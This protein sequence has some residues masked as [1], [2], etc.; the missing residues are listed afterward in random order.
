MMIH[1]PPAIALLVLLIAACDPA[2]AGGISKA[3]AKAAISR[4]LARDAARDAATSVRS[5]P[6]ARTVWRYTTI[7]GARREATHGLPP[8]VHMT[9]RTAPGRM[10]TGATARERYGLPAT[11]TAR[12]T[13][14]LP[15]GL[16]VRHNKVVAGD[17]GVG[18]ITTPKKLPPNAVLRV[19]RLPPGA[20]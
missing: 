17:R 4:T 14:T 8:G 5:L 16:P 3:V 19:Q 11:P 20:R 7:T 9:S 13:I 12:M 2:E 15:K 6:A 10:P 1:H 18:E